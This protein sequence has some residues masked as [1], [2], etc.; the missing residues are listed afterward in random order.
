MRIWQQL[1]IMECVLRDHAIKHSSFR[2]IQL[3]KLKQE[4]DQ[5]KALL[6]RT[7]QQET[8]VFWKRKHKLKIKINY[9]GKMKRTFLEKQ[10]DLLPGR[11]F[12]S[13]KMNVL[14]F[15]FSDWQIRFWTEFYFLRLITGRVQKAQ[16]LLQW[17][18]RS[19]Q[20]LSNWS[21]GNT[22]LW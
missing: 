6:G 5:A 2:N 4:H 16:Q 7:E 22:G 13:K 21:R 19:A 12:I 3:E 8:T 17:S 14:F 18:C 9:I 1:A 15:G 10:D 11:N 20:N